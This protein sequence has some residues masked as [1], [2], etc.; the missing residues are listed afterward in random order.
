M[1][2]DRQNQQ[3][4]LACL[5]PPRIGVALSNS[6]VGDSLSLNFPSQHLQHLHPM[7]S[8]LWDL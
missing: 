2:V 3:R 8:N 1:A 5:L 7:L 6:I 4:L